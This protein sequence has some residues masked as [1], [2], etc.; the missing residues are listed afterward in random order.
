M[1]P[2]VNRHNMSTR[3]LT[4]VLICLTLLV[5][6]ACRRKSPEPAIAAARVPEPGMQ[7]PFTEVER[8][9]RPA[10][11]VTYGQW[12]EHMDVSR[13]ADLIK[14]ITLFPGGVLYA[15]IAVKPDGSGFYVATDTALLHCD[16]QA[17]LVK[18]IPLAEFELGG[19]GFMWGTAM[20]NDYIWLT[21][22]GGLAIVEWRLDQPPATRLMVPVTTLAHIAV[23]RERRRVYVPFAGGVVDFDKAKFEDASWGRRGDYNFADFDSARGLL[24]SSNLTSTTGTI[25]RVDL[26]TGGQSLVTDGAFAVWGPDDWVYFC[27]GDTE[28]WRCKSDGS[29]REVVFTATEDKIVSAGGYAA[30]PCFDQSR[31]RLAYT[32]Y[33]A[34]GGGG[35]PAS[36]IVL[37]DFATQ[38]YRLLPNKYRHNFAWV[39]K[40]SQSMSQPSRP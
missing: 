35:K 25:V 7:L 9:S 15:G 12:L 18:R 2:T 10:V 1:R 32:C 38:E 28:L 20:S 6:P 4:A 17:Q 23:D 37:I 30:A 27:V 3:C 34:V 5:I 40:D 11:F 26:V 24:L 8:L 13:D 33:R 36:G 29:Q 19:G 39:V 31:S 16:T 21:C 22:S 14:G